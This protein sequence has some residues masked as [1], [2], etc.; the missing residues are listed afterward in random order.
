MFYV[1]GMRFGENRAEREI[2]PTYILK[3][4]VRF[5]LRDLNF[6]SG[7]NGPQFS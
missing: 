4:I 7:Y 5:F 3:L 1:D 2:L 6:K